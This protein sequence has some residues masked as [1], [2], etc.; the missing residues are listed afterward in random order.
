[1]AA[2]N[3]QVNTS[4][5]A[6]GRVTS[7]TNPFQSGGAPGPATT[8]QY[9]LANRAVITML[10]DGNTTR[11]DYSGSTVT[12][13]DQVSRK[14]KR[15][16]DGLGRLTKVTEQDSAG[17]LAQET[18]YTYSLLDKLTLVNQGNQARAYKYDAIGR[19]LYEN[20]PEQTATIND[21][22]GTMWTSAYAYTEYGAVK[23]KTDARGVESHY[24]FDALHQVTQ[25]WYT[26]LGGDDSGAVRPTLPSGVAATGDV[27]FAYSAWGALSGVSISSPGG[28]GYPYSETYA[29][30]SFTR[31]MSVTRTIPD[32]TWINWKTYT[33]SYEYNLGSQ[34]SK[35]IYPS[36]QQVAVNHDNIGRT[37]SL[38]YNPG[39]TSGY[40]TGMGYNIAGQVTGLTLGNGVVEN[41]GYDANRLQLTTQT[42][43]KGAT[44]LMNLTHSYQASAG[45][46][47][48]GSTAGNAAQLMGISGTIN[49]TTET[50]AYTY[51]SLRRLVTSNQTSNGSSAQRRFGYDRWGNRTGVWDAVS[52]GNQIQSITLQQSG[53][54][55]TNRI[56]SVTS[57]STLNYSCDAAGNV[58][59]DGVHSY[60]YDAEN[61]LVSVDGGATAQYK[62]DHQNRRVTKI[63]GSS[64]THYIWQGSQ[65]IGEHDATTPY[66]TNPTYQVKSARVDYVYAGARM[67]HSR[68]RTSSTGPWTTQYYLG[69]RL[70]VRMTLD[71]SGN[72][73]SRRAHLPFGEDFAE[74]GTQEKH[75]FTSYERDSESGLDYAIN[76]GYSAAAGRFFSVDRIAGDVARPQRLNRYAYTKNDPSIRLIG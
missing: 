4:Y 9:D 8:I 26:G 41:Y 71:N 36:G 70:S 76:R 14:I 3:A 66:S 51:D 75:Q 18:N 30:D 42:A 5:D 40:L 6:M 20:I 39:D 56:T 50:A 72:V 24:L 54:A 13:T 52:G 19:L 63:V 65:V 67:I 38:T 62:Y 60:S 57:G 1:V 11:S 68:H 17:A 21:G 59:N 34:L 28:I 25:I 35:M 23:K 49:S 48:S 32:H 43:V 73:S 69:D 47:G 33:T 45:Q 29:F 31:P 58:T 53:G 61:R 22:T 15:E 7:R 27:G 10:P 16:S 37:Q 46:M 2:N 12:V 74:T 44:S 55:P 64:W